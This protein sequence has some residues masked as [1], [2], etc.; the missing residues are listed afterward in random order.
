MSSSAPATSPTPNPAP[1]A[2]N[3]PA[4]VTNDAPTTNGSHAAA[5]LGSQE[6]RPPPAPPSNIPNPNS[7]KP[8]SAKNKK[9]VDSNETSKLL[10]SRIAQLEIDQAGNNEQAAEIGACLLP[11]DPKLML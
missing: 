2:A 3:G 11:S 6:P 7:K 8:G 10:A 9:P 1:F 4:Q 5:T